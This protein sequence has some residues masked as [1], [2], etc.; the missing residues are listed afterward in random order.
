MSTWLE[1]W[2]DFGRGYSDLQDHEDPSVRLG[3]SYTFALGRGNQADSDAVENSPVRLSDGTLITKEGALAPGVTLQTYDISLAA[4]DLAYKYRGFGI[5]T[6]L[7]FQNL[8]NFKGNGSLPITSTG[9]FGGFIQGGYFV[10]PQKAEIYGRTSF[11]SGAFGSGSEIGTGLNWYF[12]KGQDNLKFTFDSAWLDSS[13]AGQNRTGFVAG[14]TGLLIR[15]Q[16]SIV[17]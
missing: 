10:V 16:V 3:C 14:Q 12:L 1:P 11:V 17:F 13:P 5:S 15:T 4:L 8:L 7:Y 9:S 2:G 6:E